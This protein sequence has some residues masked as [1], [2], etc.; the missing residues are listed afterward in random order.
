MR[1]IEIFSFTGSVQLIM[2]WKDFTLTKILSSPEPY[3]A[4]KIMKELLLA[5]KSVHDYSFLHRD[6]KPSNIVLSHG[7]DNIDLKLIDF[8]MSKQIKWSKEFK[9][10]NEVGTLYFRAP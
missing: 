7:T 1:P 2:E 5:V 9:M 4:K 3:E 8:G 10:T 6:L